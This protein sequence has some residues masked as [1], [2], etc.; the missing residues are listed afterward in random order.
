MERNGQPREKWQHQLHLIVRRSQRAADSLVTIGGTY[1]SKKQFFLF[2]EAISELYLSHG[3]KPKNS[4]SKMSCLFYLQHHCL[5][6][7]QA[8]KAI[9]APDPGALRLDVTSAAWQPTNLGRQN[10][11]RGQSW[12]RT[13]SQPDKQTVNIFYFLNYIF[14]S[15]RS[16]IK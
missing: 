7:S 12:N 8:Q 9:E 3:L 6:G 14:L 1:I 5:E 13:E 11:P 10:T 16:Y 4:F 2:K 15:L